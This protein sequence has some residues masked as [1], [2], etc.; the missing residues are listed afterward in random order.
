M[1]KTRNVATLGCRVC[2]QMYDTPHK[3]SCVR[4]RTPPT[5]SGNPRVLVK[6]EDLPE[7]TDEVQTDEHG[8]NRCTSWEEM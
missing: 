8:N 1:K 7:D 4:R 2:G 6:I 3:E 5:P